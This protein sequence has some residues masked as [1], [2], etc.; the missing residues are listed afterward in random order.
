[1]NKQ[2]KKMV[3]V[4]LGLVFLLIGCLIATAIVGAMVGGETI[5]ESKVPEC[6]DPTDSRCDPSKVV[7]VDTVESYT[8]SVY[9][10]ASASIEQLGELDRVT[11]YVDMRAAAVGAI[12]GATHKVTS[13]YK[14]TATHVVLITPNGYT[15]DLDS[16]AGTGTITM[17]GVAYPI[18]ETLPDEST[19]RRLAEISEVPIVPTPTGRQLV[20]H[21]AE[22]RKLGERRNMWGGALMTSGSFTM[23]AAGGT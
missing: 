7:S 8:P 20:K 16:A 21:H 1:M 23:M 11:A 13:A 5:K 19:S 2:L 3:G 12:V 9:A 4:L 15:I 22:R 6:S 10:L 17:D 18:L 14:D